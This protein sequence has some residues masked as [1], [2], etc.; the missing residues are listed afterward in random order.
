MKRKLENTVSLLGQTGSIQCLKNTRWKNMVV[1]FNKIRFLS[2]SGYRSLK[3][4][5]H[6]AG[7]VSINRS[8]R[9]IVK[10]RDKIL[11]TRFFQ[12]QPFH[13]NHCLF[14]IIVLISMRFY[15]IFATVNN[16][17]FEVNFVN[18]IRLG[19]SCTVCLLLQ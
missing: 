14:I 3:C 13:P 9:N 7:F 19:G 6:V 11:S 5:G 1:R 12:H 10:L 15:L 2:L 18:R 16:I 4:S 8:M 17:F